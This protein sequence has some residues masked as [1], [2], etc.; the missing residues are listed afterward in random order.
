MLDCADNLPELVRNRKSYATS[1]LKRAKKTIYRI[2]RNISQATPKKVA[3]RTQ[4]QSRMSDCRD[5]V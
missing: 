3:N 4:R 5:S 1:V 2:H